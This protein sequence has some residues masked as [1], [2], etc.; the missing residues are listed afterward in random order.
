[1]TDEE[2]LAAIQARCD[3]ASPGE[4]QAERGLSLQPDV[5]LENGAWIAETHHMSDA[6]F[7]AHAREDV[8]W[9]LA[10]VRLLAGSLAREQATAARLRAAL[11]WRTAP[12][13][14]TTT[15]VDL[16]H[17]ISAVFGPLIG[18]RLPDRATV[19]RAREALRQL[20]AR[21]EAAATTPAPAAQEETR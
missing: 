3:A 1:M 7:V 5:A 6:E 12:D 18:D 14:D 17:D 9:L 4:W 20:V 13:D 8:P 19:Y 2:R 21:F 15:A 11:D 16:V 10:Q